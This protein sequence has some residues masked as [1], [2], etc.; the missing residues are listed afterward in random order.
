MVTEPTVGH[1]KSQHIETPMPL[2]RFVNAI[3]PTKMPIPPSPL[4]Y[5][6]NL[7]TL[8]LNFKII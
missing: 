5:M 2:N 3:Q 6:P 8:V 1:I 4:E 7:Q